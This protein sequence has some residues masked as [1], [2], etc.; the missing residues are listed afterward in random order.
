MVK[1]YTD[2]I[3]SD[4]DIHP[5]CLRNSIASAWLGEGESMRGIQK[6]L[7]SK[8]IA[9]TQIYMDYFGDDRK[10]TLLRMIGK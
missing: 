2:K 10:K 4:K 5:H 8:S 3:D 6:Q 1:R 7:R 9:T